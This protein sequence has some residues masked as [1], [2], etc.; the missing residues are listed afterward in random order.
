MTHPLVNILRGAMSI[1]VYIVSH[2]QMASESMSEPGSFEFPAL[3]PTMATHPD[4]IEMIVGRLSSADHAL[5]ANALQLINSLMRDA[6]G[7]NSESQWSNLIRRV[8]DLGVI[9]AVY[10]LMQGTVLYDLTHPLLDFQAMTKVLLHKWRLI[11]VDLEIPDH[12]R[13][14]KSLHLRSNA[15]EATTPIE[16][17]AQ[18]PRKMHNPD[19]WRRLGFESE[20][21]ACDF[22]EVGYLGMMDMMNYVKRNE[23][24]FQ[25]LLLEQTAKPAG[26]KCPFARASLAVTAILYEHFEVENSDLDDARFP[27]AFE[28]KKN[29][30]EMFKPMI[31]Q[32]SLLH[33]GGLQ[34]FFRL[35]QSTGAE[36]EDFMKIHDLV[37]ILLNT[38]VGGAPRNKDVRDIQLDIQ[39]FELQRLRQSQ[40]ELLELTYE[41]T[42]GD[43]FHQIRDELSQEALQFV[44]EQRIR[45]LLTGAWFRSHADEKLDAGSGA[46]ENPKLPNLPSHRYV[47][48]SY[49][50]RFL[51]Y[52]D[53]ESC[54]D[55]EP[56]MNALKEK[57]DL[58]AVTSVT[59]NVL[60]R[61][62]IDASADALKTVQR[63]ATSTKITIHGYILHDH[64]PTAPKAHSRTPSTTTRSVVAQS[65]RK[66]VTLLTLYPPTHSLASEW[67]DGLLMLLNQ[68]PITS[69]THRLLEMVNDYG[70]RI[71][72]LNVRFDDTAFTGEAPEIPSREGLDEDY[73]YDIF[74]G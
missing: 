55:H 11:P 38:V 71:R 40:M 50:R 31:L 70:L 25:K 46:K 37:R 4:F 17:E 51:H 36:Q 3:K 53:F 27:L 47:R 59:S 74:G 1:L 12:R 57:I 61:S 60:T 54:H 6:I 13:A 33:A 39:E 43:H 42:W 14:L 62:D 63:P 22:D 56:G 32:W 21:P 9:E 29:F 68:Q 8:Q 73:Y 24:S 35:W 10:A 72:L 45:C 2:P 66:E 65:L 18:E 16:N 23:N 58:T 49:N 30:N 41:D 28:S 34:A 44:K 64:W 67:L 48:L 69:E 7:N 20:N 5:C 15:E 26:Q 19:K 52:A